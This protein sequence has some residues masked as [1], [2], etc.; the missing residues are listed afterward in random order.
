MIL[1][2]ALLGA[3]LASPWYLDEPVALV[4]LESQGG[5]LPDDNLAPLLSVQSGDALDLAEVRQDVA[6]LYRTGAFASVEAH[7]EPWFTQDE[8]GEI[9]DAVWIVYRVTPAPRLSAVETS[10][11]RGQVRRRVL[12]AAD[13]QPG[14]AFFAAEDADQVA[15]QVTWALQEAGWRRARVQTEVRD[16]PGEDGANYPVLAIAVDPGEPVRIDEIR[17]AGDLVLA[18]GRLRR[19]LRA[20]GLSRGARLDTDVLA[21]ARESLGAL[22]VEQGW[23]QARVSLV[24][25]RGDRG[26]EVDLEVLVEAGP[27]LEIVASGPGVPGG[28]RLREILGIYPGDRID[29]NLPARAAEA[30]EAW[31]DR[32]GFLDAEVSASL[33]ELEEGAQLNI[34]VQRGPRHTLA[35]IDLQGVELFGE[36]FLVGAMRE[37]DEEGL[38]ESRV[39][40]EGLDTAL[41][42]VQELYRGRGHLSARAELSSL[43][44]APAGPLSRVLGRQPTV[45]RVQITEGPQT[46]LVGLEGEGLT[47][48][49]AQELRDAEEELEG[50]AYDAPALEALVSRIREKYRRAGHLD[51][52]V[53]L[54]T[55]VDPDNNEALA[56]V[57]ANPGPAYRLRSVLVTGNRKTRRRVIERRLVQEVGDPIDPVALSETRSAL[58]GLDLFRVVSLEL[59]GEGDR[60]RDLLVRVE[61]KADIQ[62]EA[63][64]GASTDLGIRVTGRALHRNLWGWGHRLTGLGQVGLAWVGESFRVDTAEPV[65]R[66]AVRYEAPDVPSDRLRLVFEVLLNEVIR[67]PTFRLS[68]SGLSLGARW[69]SLSERTEVVVD[70]R[71]QWRQLQ[72]ID[73]GA[74]VNG[75]P[76]LERLE[77]DA[78][79]STGLG[80]PSEI[81]PVG[82]VLAQVVHDGRDDRFNP[83]RGWAG[84]GQLQLWDGLMGRDPA[85]RAA[86][87]GEQLVPLG[88]LVTALGL[89]AGA[90]LALGRGETL[91]I[92]DRF[93]MGG[94]SSL[95]G[96]RLNT[97]G[98]A[99]ETSRPEIAFPGELRPLVEGTVI[100]E[101]PAH[102]VPTGGDALLGATLEL[103]I[104]TGSLGLPGG[105]EAWWVLF[106]DVGRV[107]FLSPTTF[108]DSRLRGTDPLV[109]LGLGTGL[110]LATPVGPA[111]LDLGLNLLRIEERDEPW[112]VFHL[113]LGS[114]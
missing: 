102:W 58:Y 6:L 3:A 99:N 110:R 90:G 47:P 107:G 21:E 87:R 25:A 97:V 79:T 85:L 4:T 66:A 29:Q 113:A 89:R 88:P 19:R 106:S 96:F 54:N 56:I 112:G 95:R 57:V 35:N 100:R 111:S 1:A 24:V 39:S 59:S 33:V 36:G 50:E 67:E 20:A 81:R 15:Q 23:L 48:L 55:R 18:E 104:P 84:S 37:A 27:R 72:D 71:L 2:L 41:L 9:L 91:A 82:G 42:A 61:E 13:V 74:L 11:V 63:G 34:G 52:E 51:A 77:L 40:R 64:A 109:R 103:R 10:G 14:E 38:G 26:D 5:G 70:Y 8:E 32:R 45:V 62:L 68:R 114:F 31:Y 7:V 53:V 93:T 76:W 94:P 28:P 65:W 86:A 92:E 43:D 22:L 105:D 46:R 44:H 49:V 17:L 16:G 80:L 108:T 69:E 101:D 12:A 60:Y 30:L 75:D 83:Q 98:P 78:R 73:P